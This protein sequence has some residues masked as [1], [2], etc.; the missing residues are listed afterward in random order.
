[1]LVG[2][3]IE[4]FGIG[5][6]IAAA[7]TGLIVNFFNRHV[8]FIPPVKSNTTKRMYG[9]QQLRTPLIKRGQL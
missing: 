9:L 4:S 1:M 8:C 7:I 5:T 2:L 3:A 6:I